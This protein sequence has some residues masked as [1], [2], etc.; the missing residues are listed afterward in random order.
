VLALTQD[1]KKT[2]KK[3]NSAKK[4]GGTCSCVFCIKARKARKARR[5]STFFSNFVMSG[6]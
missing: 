2:R 6:K 1:H 4:H 3:H 5:H